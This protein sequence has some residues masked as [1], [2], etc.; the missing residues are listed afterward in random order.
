[1]E[2]LE[3][4]RAYFT[5]YEDPD[6]V[7][8]DLTADAQE[9]QRKTT[10][11]FGEIMYK[12]FS[13]GNSTGEEFYI[14]LTPTFPPHFLKPSQRGSRISGFTSYDHEEYMPTIP[15]EPLQQMTSLAYSSMNPSYRH[16]LQRLIWNSLL[17]RFSLHRKK[18]KKGS[19]TSRQEMV[20]PRSTLVAEARFIAGLIRPLIFSQVRRTLRGIPWRKLRAR[21]QTPQQNI[22]R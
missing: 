16:R 17:E 12:L 18:R 11:T 19:T 14:D 9:A 7:S 13:S 2:T 22:S 8:S 4:R 3:I 1:M 6:P 5:S 20:Q 10:T 15:R 21:K